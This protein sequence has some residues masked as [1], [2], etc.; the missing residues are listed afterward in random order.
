M[1]DALDERG[2]QVLGEVLQRHLAQPASLIPVLQ[3]LNS[4]LGYLSEAVLRRVATALGVPAAQVYHV[5]TFYKAL[6]LK[7]RGRHVVKTCVGTACHVR[8]APRILDELCRSLK[9]TPGEM[10]ADGEFTLETV[11]CLGACAL[12]PIVVADGRYFS[13]VNASAVDEILAKAR[14]G[15]DEAVTPADPTIFPVAASCPMCAHSLMDR[16][17]KIDGRPSVC[18]AACCAGGTGKVRLSSLYGS[19]ASSATVAIAPGAAVDFA[20]PHCEHKLVGT[21]ACPE[22]GASMV[23]MLV[24]GGGLLQVCSRRGCPGRLLDVVEAPESAKPA[25]VRSGRA[26]AAGR[27]R[28]T[29]GRKAAAKGKTGRAR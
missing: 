23:H 8:G 1:N 24:A 25:R 10:T 16:G 26:P 28:T 5:A 20:C 29:T 19:R 18:L 7:P 17:E 11:N 2:E 27:P 4:A 13:N 6:S 14:R 21:A 12:G 9:T 3:D 22:C 15:L